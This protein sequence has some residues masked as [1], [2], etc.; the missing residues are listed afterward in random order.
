MLLDKVFCLRIKIRYQVDNSVVLKR[1]TVPW[2]MLLFRMSYSY[3]RYIRNPEAC[4]IFV[5]AYVK[6]STVYLQV[7]IIMRA[8]QSLEQPKSLLYG[9]RSTNW[10]SNIIFA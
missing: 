3:N 6:N 10:P 2:N 8:A 1:V 7:K 5:F 9:K 4:S